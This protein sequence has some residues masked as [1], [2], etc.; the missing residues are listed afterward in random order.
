MVADPGRPNLRIGIDQ[1]RRGTRDIPRVHADAVPHAVRPKH[2]PR[3]I[4]QDVEGQP[5][6]LDVAFDAI[7]RLREHTD[8]LDPTR[9]ELRGMRRKLTKLVAAIRS[10]GAAVKGEEQRPT[11]Q[12]FRERPD[13]AFLIW[14]RKVW[15]A[16]E[17]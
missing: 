13:A 5:R 2:V 16:L 7:A 14:Q 9:A 15:C 17:R 1:K 6:V 4:K 11:R 8:D 10:P 3:F 12:E